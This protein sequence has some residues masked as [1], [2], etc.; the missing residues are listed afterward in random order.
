VGQDSIVLPRFDGPTLL[1]LFLIGAM[2]SKQ[3]GA[4]LAAL[5]LSV[6]K[7]PPPPDVVSLRDW[8]DAVSRNSA[9]LPKHLAAGVLTLIDR[10]SPGTG[11]VMPTFTPA[12]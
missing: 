7:T 2:T 6:H 9:T 5:Y 11:C 12:M 4:I 10:L 3:V 1:Q 8:I